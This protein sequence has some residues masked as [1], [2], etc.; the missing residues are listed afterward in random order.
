MHACWLLDMQTIT[1]K[2]FPCEIW[3]RTR[4]FCFSQGTRN[5][6]VSFAMHEWRKDHLSYLKRK[7]SVLTINIYIERTGN[8]RLI[9]LKALTLLQNKEQKETQKYNKTVGDTE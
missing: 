9:K 6:T 2:K 8:V 3:K 5:T 7:S 1:N 4:Q